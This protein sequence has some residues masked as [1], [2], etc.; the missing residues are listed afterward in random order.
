[1]ALHQHLYF[2]ASV[3][4]CLGLAGCF[5]TE[6][7]ITTHRKEERSSASEKEA[8]P[9]SV[10]ITNLLELK[11]LPFVSFQLTPQETADIT[12]FRLPQI[13]SMLQHFE[14]V[15]ERLS[16]DYQSSIQPFFDAALSY[17]E[18]VASQKAHPTDQGELNL[19]R[20]REKVLSQQFKLLNLQGTLEKELQQ[21][22]RPLLVSLSS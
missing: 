13:D 22:F 7:D 20:A 14:S 1:M 10:P 15:Y 19:A 11:E 16:A 17:K 12:Q 3:L 8:K 4:A 18:V 21:P 6:E 5:G 9:A 2:T